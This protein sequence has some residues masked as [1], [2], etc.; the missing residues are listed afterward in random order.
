MILVFLI[1]VHVFLI[2]VH[3]LNVLFCV[4]I[5]ASVIDPADIAGLEYAL[6]NHKVSSRINFITI[7]LQ[8]FS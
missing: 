5:Q 8:L 3:C 7:L 1:A 2:V 6:D 4:E